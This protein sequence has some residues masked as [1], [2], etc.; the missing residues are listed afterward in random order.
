M[1]RSVIT[2][3]VALGVSAHAAAAQGRDR[4][5]ESVPPGQRPPPGLCRIWLNH[6]P[7]GQQPAPTDCA[8]AIRNRPEGARIIFPEERAAE[9]RRLPIPRLNRSDDGERIERPRKSDQKEKKKE[10]P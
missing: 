5:R 1:L 7:P 9:Q 2:L 8:T 6:V 3:V 4:E 10:K